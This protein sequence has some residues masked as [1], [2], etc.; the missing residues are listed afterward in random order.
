MAEE[1]AVPSQKHEGPGRECQCGCNSKPQA[2]VP[3]DE[4][5]ASERL[6]REEVIRARNKK[7]RTPSTIPGPDSAPPFSHHSGA[8]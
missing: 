6:A 2:T 3:V 8:L 5:A 4:K 7:L 1:T